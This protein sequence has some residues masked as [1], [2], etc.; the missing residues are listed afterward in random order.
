MNEL[1]EV[2]YVFLK[3][4]ILIVHLCNGTRKLIKSEVDQSSFW[5]V[6]II[7][8][9]IFVYTVLSAFQLDLAVTAF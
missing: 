8:S 1:L 2:T 5:K 3:R 7:K 6:R 9:I 4:W